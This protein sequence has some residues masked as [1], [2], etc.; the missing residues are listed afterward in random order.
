MSASDNLMAAGFA[1][2]ISGAQD[3]LSQYLGYKLKSKFRKEE[4]ADQF[5][6]YEKKLPLQIEAQRREKQIGSD[7]DFDRAMKLMPY[8]TAAKK[9]VAGAYGT[10]LVGEEGE[11][12][13][14]LPGK[15]LKLGA[16]IEEK[17]Q[18]AI[19]KKKALDKPK[20]RK[21]IRST[22]TELDEFD[23]AID[24]A[25]ASSLSKATGFLKTS[26]IEGSAGADAAATIDQVK[27]KA[28]FSSLTEMRQNSPTGASIGNASDTDIRLLQDAAAA[29]GTK[30]SEDQLRKNLLDLKRIKKRAKQNLLTSYS[31]QYEEPFDD[32]PMPTDIIKKVTEET[33]GDGI[34]FERE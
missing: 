10:T 29:L 4:L 12:I 30:Q 8:E 27:A 6:L 21:G 33:E 34:S 5:A 25:L 1:G 22:I 18:S 32:Q 19:N 2:A 14:T 28:G 15:V 7:I 24:R 11:T 23:A 9:E 13:R 16:S 17:A 3:V 20:V 26:F 31:E